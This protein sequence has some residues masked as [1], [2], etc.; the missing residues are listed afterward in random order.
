MPRPEAEDLLNAFFRWKG[1][2]SAERVFRLALANQSG[3]RSEL[4]LFTPK[5]DFYYIVY[6]ASGRTFHAYAVTLA[7][8]NR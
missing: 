3:E 6:R 2:A 4:Y 5:P 8:L 1:S 7:S